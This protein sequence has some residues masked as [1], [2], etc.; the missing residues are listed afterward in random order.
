MTQKTIVLLAGDGVSTNILFHA[1]DPTFSLARV[2]LEED[3]PM[4]TFLKR[5]V[6]QLGVV[7]VFGQILFKLLV[8]PFLRREVRARLAEIR[9]QFGLNDAQ[10]PA[11]RVTR[12][13]SVNDPAT[14]D[15]LKAL[16]PDIVLINGTRIVSRRVLE[17]VPAVFVNMHAG[18]TPLYRG[19]H[20]GYWAL[21]Q[22]DRPHCGVTVHVVDPGIDTGGILAQALIDPTP[23]DNFV[24]YPFLQ[25]GAGIPA[26][27]EILSGL[28]AMPPVLKESPAGSS[29][30]WSHPTAWGYLWRRWRDGVR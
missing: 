26:L 13:R 14:I 4:T 24:S 8:V 2:I 17:A 28:M 25:L 22:N 6:K 11:E 3:V 9:R 30:L 1:I 23:Q 29:R 21:A 10:I 16:K 19:V 15:L 5:R 7:T 12:V 20:G 18:I 27:K